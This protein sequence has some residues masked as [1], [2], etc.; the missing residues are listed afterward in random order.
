MA[1]GRG[2][3]ETASA[4]GGCAL[5]GLA[6]VHC[7][8]DPRPAYGLPG[9][10]TR[11]GCLSGSR[12]FPGQDAAR[13]GL[14]LL[15][16]SFSLAWSL[17]LVAL[18]TA[19]VCVAARTGDGVLPAVRRSNGVVDGCGSG[20]HWDHSSPG[21]HV[22]TLVAEMSVTRPLVA[23]GFPA[24]RPGPRFSQAAAATRPSSRPLPG[25]AGY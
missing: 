6:G 5:A 22:A 3:A 2:T 10:G 17:P 21:T 25:I 11:R 12:L 4:R 23:M 18:A 13:G 8:L 24:A 7:R 15:H 19:G 20:S 16:S 9:P 1:L 14:R